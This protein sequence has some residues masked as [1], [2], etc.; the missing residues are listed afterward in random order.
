MV[1]LSRVYSIKRSYHCGV[2]HMKQIE[3][4]ESITLQYLLIYFIFGCARS[5]LW[6]AGSSLQQPSLV[7]PQHVG[8]LFPDKV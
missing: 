2:A 6:P 5:S 4:Y 1:G 8:P 7:T 3:Y